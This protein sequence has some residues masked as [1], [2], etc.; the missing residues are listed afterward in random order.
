MKTAYLRCAAGIVAGLAGILAWSQLP[1]PEPLKTIKVAEGLHILEGAG[2]NVAVLTTSEGTLLIDDKFAP[3]VPQ[4]L[5]AAKSLSSQPVRYVLN[6][7]HH[8]DHTGGNAG[9]AAKEL[10]E[11]IAHENARANMIRGKQ[12]GVPRVAYQS[13]VSVTLGGIEVRAIHLGRGHTNGDAVILIPS[14]RVLHAGDLFSVPG[15]MI[16]YANGG[17]GREWIKTLDAILTLDFDTVIP[18]HGPVSKRSDVVAFRAKVAKMISDMEALRS[19]G[20]SKEDAVKAFDVKATGWEP[21]RLVG[22]VLPGLY[23]EVGK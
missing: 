3:N 13:A 21:T 8:G 14:L 6:T 19:K 22:R 1:P 17:S 7:H 15:P 9:V 12:P 10:V 20:L 4:I 11:I 2:G 18:G 23:D 5:E 16:D